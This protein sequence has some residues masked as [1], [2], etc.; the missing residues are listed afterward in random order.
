MR[1]LIAIQN[2]YYLRILRKGD[3]S[4]S[5]GLIW[6]IETLSETGTEVTEEML[7]NFLDSQA[8]RFLITLSFND[9]AIKKK[10]QE[11]K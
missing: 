6:V 5:H 7:P 4:R 10:E 1:F 2:D 9:R 3:E 8:K 11:I